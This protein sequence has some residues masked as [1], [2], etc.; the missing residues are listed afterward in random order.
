MKTNAQIC[1]ILIIVAINQL[2]FAGFGTNDFFITLYPHRSVPISEAMEDAKTNVVCRPA[3]LDPTG[4]WGRGEV[5]A[6][7]SIRFAKDRYETNEPVI[8]TVIYRNTRTDDNLNLTSAFG[9]ERDFQ[10]VIKGEDEME[11]PD[12]FVVP[13]R[14]SSFSSRWLPGTQYR[15][16][17]NLTKRYRL[18]QRGTY[19]I[20]V[21]RKIMSETNGY[22]YVSSGTAKVKIE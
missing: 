16:E 3:E 10:F 9:D 6:Q 5:G 19:S 20:S 13:E 22:V 11:L 2:V 8:A 18:S 14:V 4:H 21:R 15:Y 7:L 12:S 1:L 17:S